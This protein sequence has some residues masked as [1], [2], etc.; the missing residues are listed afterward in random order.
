MSS[1]LIRFGFI[2]LI[3]FVLRL[4]SVSSCSVLYC[5]SFYFLLYFVFWF[6]SVLLSTFV[7]HVVLVTDCLTC[8]ALVVTSLS[9]EASCFF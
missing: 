3:A 4:C 1:S 5:G 9:V 8:S 7:S 2:M 6:C